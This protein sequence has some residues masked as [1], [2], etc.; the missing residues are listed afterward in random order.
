M[1][2]MPD[3]EL[4]RWMRERP[5]HAY[6]EWCFCASCARVAGWLALAWGTFSVVVLVGAILM[7]RSL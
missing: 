1:M 6:E 5:P 7:W 3:P 4:M 2:P